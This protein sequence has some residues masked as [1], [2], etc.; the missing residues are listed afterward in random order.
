MN[1]VICENVAQA[2]LDEPLVV[3]S[4]IHDQPPPRALQQAHEVFNHGNEVR[5]LPRFYNDAKLA[6]GVLGLHVPKCVGTQFCVLLQILIPR[7]GIH[8]D[9]MGRL[10]CLFC[11]SL[12]LNEFF[13]YQKTGNVVHKALNA[14]TA[15]RCAFT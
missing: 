14:M 15:L 11:M 4:V 10:C 8:A 13:L 5:V 3:G 6:H 2:V 12:F 1:A 9:Y 7:R